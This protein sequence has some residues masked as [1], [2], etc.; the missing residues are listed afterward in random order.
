MLQDAREK[1][2]T[3]MIANFCLPLIR[4]NISEKSGEEITS[5]NL[6]G[7]RGQLSRS[8]FSYVQQD[9]YNR[10]SMQS[11]QNE[12]L[13]GKLKLPRFGGGGGGSNEL[14]GGTGWS[15]MGGK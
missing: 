11:Q 2:D 9:R 14:A 4:F 7:Y 15:G 5:G 12:G 8:N 6:G 13:L 10:D 3:D 1:G